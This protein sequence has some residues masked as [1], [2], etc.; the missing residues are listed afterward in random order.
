M[1]F[2]TRKEVLGEREQI[3][4]SW[5]LTAANEFFQTSK[6]GLDVS[7]MGSV[8]PQINQ[9]RAVCHE[10]NIPVIF[11]RVGFNADYSVREGMN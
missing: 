9:L 8:A 6:I 11:A 10:R 4:S 1:A 5:Y 2:V 3:Y 7:L